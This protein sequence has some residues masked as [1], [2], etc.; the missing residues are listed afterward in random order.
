MRRVLDLALLASLVGASIFLALTLPEGGDPSRRARKTLPLPSPRPSAPEPDGPAETLDPPAVVDPATHERVGVEPIGPPGTLAIIGYSYLGMWEPSPGPVPVT[1]DG[2]SSDGT[3]TP[4]A[5]SRGR[6]E[7]HTTGGRLFLGEL[8]PDAPALE[9]A[10]S[11]GSGLLAV[12]RYP[13][14]A[15]P[16]SLID[17]TCAIL[18]QPAEGGI[19]LLVRGEA[20]L[21][22]GAQI[23]VRVIAADHGLES[24]LLRVQDRRFSGEV[25]VSPR[26]YHAGGYQLQFAWG[27]GLASRKVLEQFVEG[28]GRISDQ[29][30]RRDVG[31]FFGTPGEARRQEQD[32]RVYYG[33]ALAGMEGVRDLLLVAG[34]QARGKRA[35]LLREPER[36]AGM[37]A[38]P[39]AGRFA[40]LFAEERL[41]LDEWRR[42]IDE[43]IP[44]Y[45]LPY[46]DADAM[47]FLTKH[48]QAAYNLAMLAQHIRKF[49]RLES[50]VTYEALGLPR[51]PNDFVANF[52][53]EP[54]T[55]REL[56][57]QRIRNY[58]GAIR[59]YI[60]L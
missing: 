12:H 59:Q 15:D 17:P 20:N 11:G 37:R 50:T 51:H 49:S 18:W 1:L 10:P 56:T 44:E 47:P 21:P 26:E 8:G 60:G 46:S 30:F 9:L 34:S 2:P 45:L 41:R 39:L 42:M 40:P 52:D 43:V 38:H 53:F 36:V 29:E 19:R 55:E 3:R 27:R 24:V 57:L 16:Q 32:A 23:A 54:E 6:F 35:K 7:I 48:P 58:C 28:G 4:V 5:D 14:A 13:P 31:V 33:T 22:D 25:P